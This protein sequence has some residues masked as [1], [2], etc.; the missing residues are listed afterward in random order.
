[1]PRR[2]DEL[3][4]DTLAQHLVTVCVDFGTDSVTARAYAT[5]IGMWATRPRRR[6]GAVR[7]V[8]VE[9]AATAVA[10]EEEAGG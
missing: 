1:M 9:R 10:A 5:A 6:R 3:P 8:L 7:E 4:L 2:L